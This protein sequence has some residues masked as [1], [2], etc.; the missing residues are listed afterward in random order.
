MPANKLSQ[1]GFSIL[2]FYSKK[3]KSLVS[4]SK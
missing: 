2:G 4:D 1:F 3:K